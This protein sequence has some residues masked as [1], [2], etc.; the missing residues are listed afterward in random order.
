MKIVSRFAGG[1]FSLLVGTNSFAQDAVAEAEAPVVE[2]SAYR[3]PTLLSDT[4]QGVNL[5]G[6]EE[7][8]TQNPASVVDL[9]RQVPGVY[10]DQLGGPGGIGNVYIRG[11]DPENVLVL[12]D[13]VRVNDS[14]LSRGGAYDLST[15]DSS[16]IERIEI[17]KGPASSLYG[18]DAMGGLIN[19]VTKYPKG[20][21]L[22]ASIGAG[23][24]GQG[25]RQ[26]GATGAFSSQSM[27]AALGASILQD[28][29]QSQ[30]GD[31]D[32]RSFHG[33][34]TLKPMS[35]FSARLFGR[36]NDRESTGFPDTSGGIRYS[37]FRTLEQ[38]DS[39]ENTLGAD[40]SFVP[41]D[42]LTLRALATT[43]RRVENLNSPGVSPLDT[44][45]A[46][47]T[48]TEFERDSGL[49]SASLKLPANS[50]FVVGYE[51][52]RED[53]VSQGTQTFL[54][55]P[56]M[57]GLDSSFDLDRTTKSWFAEFKSKPVTELVLQFG[58]RRDS[59]SVFGSDINPSI[60]ARYDF[61][62]SGTTI[63]AHYAEGF[64]P[65]SF[66]A[67]GEPNFGNPALVPETSK[68]AELAFEQSFLNDRYRIGLSAFKTQT[69]NLIDFDFS[70]FKLV[71]RNKVDA[72]GL[73]LEFV[74]KPISELLIAFSHTYVE[75]EI[76]NSTDQL[77]H[78]PKN[79]S[80]LRA[81]YSL[82][83]ALSFSWSTAYV[84]SS[85]DSSRPT[86]DVR[87]GGYT[88]TDVGVVYRWKQFAASFN[89]DNLFDK[90]YEQFVGFAHPGRRV[91][92]GASASF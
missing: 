7:I 74:A 92:A 45:G 90:G 13:G 2:V 18:A 8:E 61:L 39:N 22:R 1:A 62:D 84:G 46:L 40:V 4:T 85:F 49:V 28:G 78:R 83:E 50:D 58:L 30:G 82:D 25:Y 42:K 59:I 14:T 72:K 67:L 26:A 17:V 81:V 88:R 36:H 69:E 63:K 51:R 20:E 41:L 80:G 16:G 3:L 76:V 52:L 60:G 65:P 31:L 33:A 15:L 91:R 11:S 27:Q 19:V 57:V 10:V 89:I 24:G 48:R 29:E 47:V 87:L 55:G 9:M 35:S 64:R 68:S 73:E 66:F 37:V 21:G 53:G 6:R 77:A 71:N 5:I 23:A 75:T 38:R 12:I 43:Y 86:G 34:I 44:V 79:R 56:V 70:T 32:V 54:F